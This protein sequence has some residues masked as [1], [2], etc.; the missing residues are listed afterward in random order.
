MVNDDRDL[1]TV[2]KEELEFLE[3]GGYQHSPDAPWRSRFIFEDS[4]TCLNHDRT[5]KLRPCSECVLISLVPVD[6]RGEKIPC[7]HIALNAAGF[8]IDTYYR[9]GTHEEVE[10][11]MAAWLHKTIK[12][13]E[14]ERER[15]SKNDVGAHAAG[16]ILRI[17]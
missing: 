15:R 11:A 6:C 13:L 10:E 2:L 5:Q 14:L 17:P 1:L 16:A 3:K 8:T 9:L 7:R 4:P 12:E